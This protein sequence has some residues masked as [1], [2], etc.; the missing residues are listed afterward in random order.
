MADAGG[1]N[2]MAMGGEIGGAGGDLIGG[3]IGEAM[4]RG[5]YEEA[6]R[7]KKLAAQQFEGIGLPGDMAQLGPSSLENVAPDAQS[8]QARR[9][10]LSRMMQVGFEGGMDPESRAAN[11][12]ARAGAAQYEASQRGAIL[13]AQKRRGMLGA[14]TN[15]AAQLQASQAGAN[16]VSSAGIQAAADARKRALAAMQMSGQMAGDL[17]RD[18]YGQRADLADRRDAIAEFNARNRQGF[19]QQNFQNQMGLAGKKY[20]V[21]RDSADDEQE[22][23]DKKVEKGRGYGRAAGGILG[24]IGGAAAL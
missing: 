9:D 11:A 8:R 18:D 5:D 4:A 19:A 2:P 14:G 13:D 16:R 1:M 10:I 22:K 15:V 6:E 21:Y 23:G 7:L 20:N 17:E 12:E 24:T 3:L